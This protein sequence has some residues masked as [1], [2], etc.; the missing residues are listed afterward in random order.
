MRGFFTRGG[1]VIAF[2]TSGRVNDHYRIV[3]AHTDSPGL[4]VKTAP[5]GQAFNFGTLEVEVY[6]SPLL[7]SW[8]DR[9]LDL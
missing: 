4:F 5:E 7:N 6:G 8:L 1:A 3:G 2:V 9:D